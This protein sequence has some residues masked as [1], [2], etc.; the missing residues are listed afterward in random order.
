VKSPF[1][2]RGRAAVL[3]A[4]A[5]LAALQAAYFP[6]SDSWPQLRDA[7]Y[8]HKLANLRAQVRARAAGQP[9]V[10]MLGSSLTGMGFN[11]S[12]MSTLRPGGPGGPV[13]FN[14]GINSSGVVVQ[15]VMLRRLL[16]EGIRPDLVLVE[17]HPWFLYRGYN[18]H[19]NKHYLA[20]QRV[21]EEDLEVLGRYDPEADEVRKE[22]RRH[23]WLPW[24]RDRHNLLRYFLASW[25]PLEQQQENWW[26][27]T[28]R[29]GW[30][31]LSHHI[32]KTKQMTREKYVAS[33]HHH[34]NAMNHVPMEA[35]F[36][37]AYRELVRTCQ[38]AGVAV[39]VVRMPETSHMRA[40]FSPEVRQRI[41][42]A[43]TDLGEETGVRVIDGRSWLGDEELCD[44]FHHTLNGSAI[45]TR[46]LERE[47]LVP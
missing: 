22:G 30:E 8:G 31:H 27:F 23:A 13:V 35:V 7:E 4:V 39:V 12:A 1:E 6:L 29:H 16:A 33:I 47:C 45:F 19:V 46:R 26:S 25:T 11:P 28:D 24:Y 21:R 38:E 18:T 44:G 37:D 5:S 2:R 10:V 14:F 9:C 34:V 32:A 3:W 36:Q 41:D 43:F 20:L 17:A 15:L 42:R 40:G